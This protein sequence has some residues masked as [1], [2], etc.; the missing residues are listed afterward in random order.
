M[1]A[2]IL[3]S[4]SLWLFLRNNNENLS[5]LFINY[6]YIYMCTNQPSTIIIVN[7]FQLRR[8]RRHTRCSQLHFIHSY[9]TK[10]YSISTFG[11]YVQ[12]VFKSLIGTSVDSMYKTK[13]NLYTYIY[14]YSCTTCVYIKWRKC[15][16]KSV[17]TNEKE[18]K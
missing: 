18:M 14:I 9:H 3:S 5:Y 8:H 13:L 12:T 10:T 2:N 15:V 11:Y 17:K 6:V 1:D 4:L 16:S 7:N